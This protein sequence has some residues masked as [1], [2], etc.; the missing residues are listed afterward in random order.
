MKQEGKP[1][2]KCGS[3]EGNG[4]GHGVYKRRR[5]NGFLKHLNMK[6]FTFGTES[7]ANKDFYFI[8]IALRNV[9]ERFE[10]S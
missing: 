2:K 4:T 1:V 6:G 10:G 3:L 7:N 8:T 5:L 9:K